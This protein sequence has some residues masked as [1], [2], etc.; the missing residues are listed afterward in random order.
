MAEQVNVRFSEAKV[1]EYMEKCIKD[2]TICLELRG[3]LNVNIPHEYGFT[4]DKQ[5]YFVR[6]LETEETLKI[7]I[8]L[9]DAPVPEEKAYLMRQEAERACGY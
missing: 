9:K 1:R 3:M 2:G 5:K 8:E 7:F 6:F 4:V